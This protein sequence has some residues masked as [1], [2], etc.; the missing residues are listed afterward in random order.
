MKHPTVMSFR[1]VV[2]ILVGGGCHD[3]VEYLRAINDGHA[4]EASGMTY[5]QRHNLYKKKRLHGLPL[6]FPCGVVD[7]T[8]KPIT[9]QEPSNLVCMD[10]DRKDNLFAYFPWLTTMCE[11]A[12]A[13]P[14]GW[15]AV[16]EE[17]ARLFNSTCLICVSTSG[18][19]VFMLMRF[20]G[21][22]D[23]A[24]DYAVATLAKVGINAD[25]GAKA[26]AQFR[27]FSYDPKAYVNYDPVTLEVPD[28]WRPT[29]TTTTTATSSAEIEVSPQEIPKF[30]AS[31]MKV[32]KQ[33]EKA[34]QY[35]VATHTDITRTIDDWRKLKTSIYCAEYAKVIDNGFAIFWTF[36]RYYDHGKA[37]A[38][39]NKDFYSE[40]LDRVRIPDYKPATLNGLWSLCRKYH[41]PYE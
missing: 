28:D 34:L 35:V 21:D 14:K 16:S 4:A 6:F 11:K 27:Y 36:G 19:G 15:G 3:S 1:D 39:E 9:I 30:T 23:R 18:T 37:D 32:Q 24:F 8:T 25:M 20:K 7:R 33:L 41:V 38:R 10:I 2:S 26:A 13:N 29:T 22:R 5:E 17:T 12:K 31:T 40:P